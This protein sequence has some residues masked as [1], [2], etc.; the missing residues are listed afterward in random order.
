MEPIADFES[1]SGHPVFVLIETRFYQVREWEMMAN[2]KKILAI[3]AILAFATPALADGSKVGV[4]SCDVSAGIGLILTQSQSVSCTFGAEGG[5]PKDFYVG[6]IDSFGV[7]LG[8]V[9]AGQLVWGVFASSGGPPRGALAGTYAG[10]GAQATAG[11]GV[12]GNVL[13]GGT[14]RSFSLQP[15]SVQAQTGLNVAGGVTALTLTSAK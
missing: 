2:W 10:V 12:G 8:G 7:A 6:H 14:G 13:V 11:V 4:L 1:K 15:L 3:G 5:G 9:Q